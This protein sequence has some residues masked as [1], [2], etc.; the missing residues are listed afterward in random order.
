MHP[1]VEA[2][3]LDLEPERREIAL[4][5]RD[6]IMS[7]A[8]GVEEAFKWKVPFYGYRG[9]LCYINN[10]KQGLDLGFLQGHLL[11]DPSGVLED[12]GTKQV[13][14]LNLRNKEQ[15]ISESFQQILQEALMQNEEMGGK[16]YSW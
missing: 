12:R 15:L 6:L 8:P 4:L 3:I 2:Y 13:R 14:H 9:A 1:Q 16:G 11:S 10:R 5:L 7:S